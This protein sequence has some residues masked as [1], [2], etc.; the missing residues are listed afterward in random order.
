M[1]YIPARDMVTLIIL[2]N[3]TIFPTGSDETDQQVAISSQTVKFRANS[4]IV[5]GIKMKKLKKG[6]L[7]SN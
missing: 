4:Q 6:E 7:K 2:P 1:K 5:T 3:F